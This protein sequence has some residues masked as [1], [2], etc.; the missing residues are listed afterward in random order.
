[1]RYE[2]RAEGTVEPR[3]YAADVPSAAQRPLPKSMGMTHYSSTPKRPFNAYPATM[4]MTR[5]SHTQWM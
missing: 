5:N 4:E 1:M 3:A 2:R